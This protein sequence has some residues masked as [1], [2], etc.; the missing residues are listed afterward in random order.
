VGDQTHIPRVRERLPQ[1][2][3]IQGELPVR[4]KSAGRRQFPRLV[5]VD[6][7]RVV[8]AER[9]PVD[10]AGKGVLLDGEPDAVLYA[11]RP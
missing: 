3:L 8:L 2:H 1:P 9:E 6:F 5:V 11:E 10:D 4:L 7:V